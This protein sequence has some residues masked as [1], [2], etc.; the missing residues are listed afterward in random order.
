VGAK[1]L[2]DSLILDYAAVAVPDHDDEQLRAG[3]WAALVHAVK[4]VYGLDEDAATEWVHQRYQAICEAEQP[5][6]APEEGEGP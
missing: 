2:I 1:T 5:A 6:G 3:Y 4:T